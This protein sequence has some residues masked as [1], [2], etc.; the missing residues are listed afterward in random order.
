[1][2]T[3]SQV[4]IVH[5]PDRHR[6]EAVLDDDVVGYAEYELSDGL[7]TFTHTVVEPAYEGRG[8]ASQLIRT[9]L[10]EIRQEGTR[11]V[12]PVCS[13]VAGWIDH[14]PDHA[15]LLAP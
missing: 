1:M 3:D 11:K 14:H 12:R 6:W 4:R 5:R 10:D 2:S 7:A 8:I 13:Y 15:D 9:A